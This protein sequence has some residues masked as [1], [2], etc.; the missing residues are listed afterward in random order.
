MVPEESA[1]TT[2]PNNIGVHRL[3]T[4]KTRPAYVMDLAAL[5]VMPPI[6]YP[7]TMLNAAVNY[8]EHAVEMAARSR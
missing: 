3:A 2:T 6:M 8:R 5:K 7:M 1:P 4:A